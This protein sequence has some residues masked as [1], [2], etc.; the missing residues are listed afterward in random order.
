MKTYVYLF[1]LTTVESLFTR[2]IKGGINLCPYL[3]LN[4]K[5]HQWSL[6]CAIFIAYQYFMNFF[7]VIAL[8]SSFFLHQKWELIF[9]SE[10]FALNIWVKRFLTWVT[11]IRIRRSR[12]V[13][14][15]EQSILFILKKDILIL[16]I[17]LSKEIRLIFV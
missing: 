13:S 3:P 15:L 4:L 17:R 12:E 8:S 16:K 11:T 7:F 10:I 2:Q 5:K 1:L 14:S 9:D 6:Y